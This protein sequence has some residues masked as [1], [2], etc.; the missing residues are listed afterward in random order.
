MRYKE[1]RDRNGRFIPV[2]ISR[3]KICL[4]CGKEFT[5]SIKNFARNKFC[6]LSCG[7]RFYPSGRLGKKNSQYQK[8]MVRLKSSG[9]NNPNWKGDDVGYFALHSWVNRKLGIPDT[10]DHCGKSGLTGHKIHWAN[11]N[12]EYNRDLA[13]W[14]RL[15]VTCHKKYDKI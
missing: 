13:D 12:H 10:C 5:P 2:I 7:S 3:V 8:D 15:C 11:K 4:Y 6:S 1:K 9:R 14:L